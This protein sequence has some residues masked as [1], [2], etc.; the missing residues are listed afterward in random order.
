MLYLARTVDNS[1]WSCLVNVTRTQHFSQCLPQVLVIIQG[2]ILH[3][4]R[5]CVLEYCI[6]LMLDLSTELSLLH[7]TLKQTTT[8]RAAS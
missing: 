5:L 7:N 2:L 4:F 6:C 3:A 1:L 8:A